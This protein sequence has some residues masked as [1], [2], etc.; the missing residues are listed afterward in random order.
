[1][2]TIL[3]HN[4]ATIPETIGTEILNMRGQLDGITVSVP[5]TISVSH[6]ESASTIL[7]MSIEIGAIVIPTVVSV[8]VFGLG[9][10]INWLQKKRRCRSETI[11]FRN[12]L[13]TWCDMVEKPVRKQCESLEALSDDIVS[14][15]TIQGVRYSFS[16]SMVQ[17]L[18]IA[19][20]ENVIQHLINRSSAKKGE[21]KRAVFA[22]NMVSQIDYLQS[23]EIE[24]ARQYDAYQIQSQ[25][26]LPEWNAEIMNIKEKILA[27]PTCS[28]EQIML[29]EINNTYSLWANDSTS[30][31]Y[32][33]VFK[34]QDRL[35]LP[36]VNAC[37]KQ[38]ILGQEFK[39]VESINKSALT[40]LTIIKRWQA[41]NLGFSEVFRLYSR[42][43]SDSIDSLMEAV[44]YFKNNTKPS[45]WL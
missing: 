2:D 15:K 16:K 36:I 25:E 43:E 1:M 33:D 9:I 30:D 17:H 10:V 23:V 28:R 35:L 13:F 45:F 22:F 18:E 37:N 40:L 39:N 34:I 26:F 27:K 7:G 38:S 21:D 32:V 3:V 24:I 44:C 4:Q 42:C 12:A 29:Q 14:N 41:L 31:E 6:A 20:A 11:D 19:S 8:V 5:D